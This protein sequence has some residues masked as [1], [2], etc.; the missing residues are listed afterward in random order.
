MC[1]PKY[2]ANFPGC[3]H[4]WTGLIRAY[5]QSYC[6]LNTRVE[7]VCLE[8][9]TFPKKLSTSVKLLNQH[10]VSVHEHPIFLDAFCDGDVKVNPITGV[11]PIVNS[12]LER[13]LH[14]VLGLLDLCP[15]LHE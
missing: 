14:F 13:V 3:A 1:I 15:A 9:L 8:T 4:L 12:A 5:H 6:R 7:R 2:L 11:L 10:D